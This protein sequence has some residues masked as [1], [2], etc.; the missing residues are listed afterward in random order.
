MR[1]SLKWALPL[2]C[3]TTILPAAQAWHHHYAAPVPVGGPGLQSFGVQ[4]Y[5]VQA[6]PVQSYGVQAFPVQSYGV[7]AFP[8]QNYS[9]QGYSLVPTLNTNQ[10]LEAQG[11]D[12]ATILGILRQLNLG[13]LGGAGGVT[14]SSD[15]VRELQNNTA[16]LKDNTAALKALTQAVK[17]NTASGSDTTT[18]SPS[19]PINQLPRIPG[20]NAQALQAAYAQAL[21]DQYAEA[22]T[23]KK[24]AP[25]T[26]AD[27]LTAARAQIKAAND[28]VIAAKLYLNTAD[29][30]N[31]SDA[32]EIKY[33]NDQLKKL[34]IAP[35]PP[36]P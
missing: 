25:A 8:V 21:A 6:F 34:G 9:V 35:A 22:L 2:A 19:S 27:I 12:I 30:R 4:S 23:S 14:G 10:G 32:D 1:N 36:K 29:A 20:V 16:A 5:G 13:G 7:Q 28:A 15:M 17:D 31:A 26:N 18:T 33:L 24:P 11:L 3:L